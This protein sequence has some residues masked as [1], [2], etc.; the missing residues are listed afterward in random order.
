MISRNEAEEF[1]DRIHSTLEMMNAIG[2]SDCNFPTPG[3]GM[4]KD[5][6]MYF[7]PSTNNIHLGIYGILDAFAPDNENELFSAINYV[8]GH[9]EQHRRSTASRPYAFAI[10]AGRKAVLEYIQEELDGYKK[11]FRKDSEYQIYADDL[12]NRGVYV[13]WNC[14][15]QIAA[16]ICNC[17]EDGRIER[18]RGN[19]FPGFANLRRVFRGKMWLTS[20]LEFKPYDEIKDDAGEKLTVIIDQILFLA[21]CNIYSMGFDIYEDTPLQTEVD[22]FMPDIVSAVKSGNTRGLIAPMQNICYK[23][24]PYIFEVGKEAYEKNEAMDSLAQ[25]LSD[26]LENSMLI[27]GM[28]RQDNSLS[29]NDEDTDD[30][31]WNQVF[32]HSD[33]VLTL[34]DDEYDKM[35]E[36]GREGSNGEGLR[37]RREHPL[38]DDNEGEQG[39][40]DG[41]N[42]SGTTS[43]GKET[44]SDESEGSN[45]GGKDGEN[46]KESSDSNQPN[47]QKGKQMKNYVDSAES[48]EDMQG[49]TDSAGDASPGQEGGTS[50]LGI[51]GSESE[52]HSDGKTKAV[53]HASKEDRKAE[54]MLIRKEM[55]AAAATACS[56]AKVNV[57]SAN[58]VN[59]KAYAQNKGK[60]VVDTSKP[61]SSAEMKDICDFIELHRNYAVKDN[62]PSAYMQRGKTLHRKIEQY[63]KSI[64]TPNVSYLDS[65]LIDPSRLYGL[66]MGDT[67]IFRKDGKEKKFDGCAYIL[68]DNSGSMY[69]IKREEACK[70]AAI[71]EEGFKG[72]MPF[73]I[74]A[75]DQGTSVIHEVVKNW[76]EQLNKNCCWNFCLHGR[77]G[78]GNDDGHDIMVATRELMARPE[79]KKLLIVLSD[80]TPAD[81]ALCKR[82][83]EEA[84]KKG[85]A[86]NG[87]YFEIGNCRSNNQFARMYEKDY[88]C[89]PLNELDSNLV[90]I[91]KKFALH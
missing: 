86:V 13:D 59:A 26:L 7:D 16:G 71:I 69:G 43:S 68:I 27:S 2:F 55:E 83:I 15:D 73:K 46:K 23:L 62:L 47:G 30:G 65:G 56:E 81:T 29:E 17:L 82:S 79:K 60:E 4:Y 57:N 19:R 21:T 5:V 14:I 39:G 28:E 20:Q 87:I 85:I 22:S 77:N 67:Q 52:G 3:I 48:R 88:I 51:D 75:F 41:K 58:A 38:E 89:C 24:A 90:S 42:S 37:I 8:R 32:S 1:C 49:G 35:M 18:L 74:V 64:S 11:H 45:G 54:E 25:L 63:F 72:I 9:E 10:S 66:A 53:K 40:K 12:P 70:A 36:N 6:D 34:P 33:I 76:D 84:R 80:G 91:M 44:E 61:I 50:G 31:S 78:G